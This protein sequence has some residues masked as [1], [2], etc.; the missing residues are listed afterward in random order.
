MLVLTRKAKE[1]IHIGNDI[2]ITIIETQ[3]GKTRVGI[4]APPNVKIVRGE[5]LERRKRLIDR[6]HKRD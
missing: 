6:T 5:I 1:T 2:V 4:E 3:G